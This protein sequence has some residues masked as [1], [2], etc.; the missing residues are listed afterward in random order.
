MPQSP[1]RSA[2]IELDDAISLIGAMSDPTRLRLLSLILHNGEICVCDLIDITELPQPKVSRHL[3]TLRH[4][5]WVND[6][7]E[8]Q[9]MHYSLAAATSD[10]HRSLI[11]SVK[12]AH[13]E[14]DLV[15][16]DLAKLSQASCCSIPSKTLTQIELPKGVR[17]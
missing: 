1:T 11:G 7:R 13:E 15:R 10:L 16:D 12:H 17:K 5:G 4:A 8:G 2:K 3:A 6:R 14:I 9:W